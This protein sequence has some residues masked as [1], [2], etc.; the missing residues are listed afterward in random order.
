MPSVARGVGSY[1]YIS[2]HRKAVHLLCTFRSRGRL[3]S[4]VRIPRPCFHYG[5]LR[6]WLSLVA[7]Q[8]HRNFSKWRRTMS[9]LQPQGGAPLAG[10]HYIS[11]P[12]IY[13][14]DYGSRVRRT[15]EVL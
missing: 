6:P 5:S 11:G 4:S 15:N 12:P 3:Q 7:S 2:S 1:N 8:R 14:L 10:A 13:I 9:S